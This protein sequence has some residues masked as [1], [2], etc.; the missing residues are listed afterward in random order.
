MSLGFLSCIDESAPTAVAAVDSTSA[1]EVFGG[2]TLDLNPTI[3]FSADGR[4][5][6]Y[7]NA[8]NDSGFPADVDGKGIQVNI[9]YQ[10]GGVGLDI[11]F[12]ADA[13][14]EGALGVTVQDFKDTGNDGGIDEFT[15]SAAKV[16]DKPIPNF[17]PVVKRPMPGEMKRSKADLAANPVGSTA[18]AAAAEQ[19]VDISGAP[20]VTEW[21]SNIVGKAIEIVGQGGDKDLLSFTSPDSG[22]MYETADGFQSNFTYTYQKLSDRGRDNEGMITITIEEMENGVKMVDYTTN[23]LVFTD[24]YNGTY[25]QIVSTKTNSATGVATPDGTLDKGTFKIELDTSG[26]LKQNFTLNTS[27]SSGADAASSTSSNAASNEQT[28]GYPE[29]YVD[30]LG[31]GL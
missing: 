23:D 17:K 27:S 30:T 15:V 20:T 14:T 8:N 1:A 18:D 21:N 31:L 12:T 28:T 9:T 29:G 6:T 19:A 26:Y 10:D 4:S 5:G 3:V 11:T 16:G 2:Y 22:V 13:F 7:T 25:E 24:W